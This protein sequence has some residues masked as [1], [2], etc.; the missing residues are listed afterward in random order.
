VP[1]QVKI[2]IIHADFEKEVFRP[3][4][5]R[6]PLDQVLV[7]IQLET[8]GPLIRLPP[9]VAFHLHPHIVHILARRRSCKRRVFFEL[10]A[11][12]QITPGQ[13]TYQDMSLADFSKQPLNAGVSPGGTRCLIS[14][15]P[16]PYIRSYLPGGGMVPISR[17]DF[18]ATTLLSSAALALGD[19]AWPKTTEAVVR[20]AGKE[21]LIIRSLRFYDLET[22]VSL[23]NSWIT[24]VDLFFV[25]NHMSEPT[26][27]DPESYRLTVVGEVEHPLALTLT[28]FK[29]LTVATVTN[30]LECAGNGRAFYQPHVPGVQW[31]RGAVGTARYTGPRLRDI[32]MRAGLKASAKHVAFKGL[33]EPPSK[34]PPFIRSI[35]I[36]KAL[37]PETLL[38]T[39]M[40]GAP[41][42]KHHGY[43]VRAKRQIAYHASDRGFDGKSSEGYR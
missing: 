39:Q 18:L 32:L 43:P 20:V 9:R 30:T 36:E 24:P 42:L 37:D 16:F 11:P 2:A 41:L 21:K 34:V 22:P 33:D 26:T 15:H 40:N 4:H 25:R 1:Q 28:E 38:A 10:T 12:F 31:Q 3:Y 8:D 17:R 5:C 7:L 13:L 6:A 35:P 27:F 19:L 14:G 29:K 23:L